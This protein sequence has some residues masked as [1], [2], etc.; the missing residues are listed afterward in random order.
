MAS[1]AILAQVCDQLDLRFPKKSHH[2]WLGARPG[3]SGGADTF[4][5][6]PQVWEGT[7]P[8]GVQFRVCR[9]AGIYST[10]TLEYNGNALGSLI[11]V[12]IPSVAILAQAGGGIL[13]L[14]S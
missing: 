14:E 4:V 3:R 5:H 6:L 2:L 8:T 7:E 1:L 12:I 10:N 9:E 11:I 13:R